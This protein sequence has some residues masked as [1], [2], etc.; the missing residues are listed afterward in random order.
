M[1]RRQKESSAKK[2]PVKLDQQFIWHPFTQMQDWIKESPLVIQSGKG[3]VLRDTKGDSYLD[4]NASIWTNLHGHN[5][6]K[7]NR[8][9]ERQLRK[10]SHSSA[11][12]YANEPASYLAAELISQTRLI[13]AKTKN[14]SNETRSSQFQRQPK[15]TKVFFSDDGSTAMEAALKLHHQH[16]R[17]SRPHIT[18]RYLSLESS[19]HGDTVGAMSLSHSPLFHDSFDKIRFSVDRVMAPYCYRCP[20]NQ[21]RP[22]R[23]D[24]RENRKC[25]WECI[26]QIEKQLVKAKRQKKPYT[27]FVLEPLVQGAAGMIPHPTGYLAKTER[28]VRH[29]GLQLIADEVLTGFGRTGSMIASHQEGVQPDFLALAKGL[30]G[31]YLPMAATLTTQE[32]FNSF[33]GPYESF[34]S[35]FHG[36][37][38]TGNQLGSAAALTSLEI[39]RSPQSIQRRQKL[40]AWF[41][42]ALETLWGLPQVGDIRQVG[43]IAGIE[44]V[45]DWSS[46]APYPLEQQAGIR[47]CRA[48]A[49]RGVLTRPV[50]NV[51]VIVLIYTLTKKQL[52][53]IIKALAESIEEV[54]R[55][56]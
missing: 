24:A 9:I 43:L 37:S 33:L 51:V 32:V 16:T 20:Y 5:H 8:A 39:L 22:K 46:R 28:L 25:Q 4:A 50:G 48:M 41:S 1:P 56:Q 47:V 6:P 13:K 31:G 34:R 38:F 19:Y 18:P 12:G 55:D 26:G 15:L 45:K 2:D 27:A 17:R 21:A 52:G 42:S 11:L 10:I 23:Q 30:T 54:L 35:F 36:H 7:I 29:H 44:L 3:A 49:K 14:Q 53:I 40:T